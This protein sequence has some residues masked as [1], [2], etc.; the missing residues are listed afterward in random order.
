MWQ[1]WTP[2]S[3]AYTSSTH[4]PLC[5]HLS[6]TPVCHCRCEYEISAQ[7][8]SYCEKLSQRPAN[9]FGL[10]RKAFTIALTPP[11]FCQFKPCSCVFST[12][13]QSV[14]WQEILCC[15]LV[16]CRKPGR[17]ACLENGQHGN[18]SYTMWCNAADQIWIMGQWTMRSWQGWGHKSLRWRGRQDGV[19]Y[20]WSKLQGLKKLACSRPDS[21]EGPGQI[22]SLAETRNEKLWFN[23]FG[24]VGFNYYQDV[25][26]IADCTYLHLSA[27]D[28]PY[29]ASA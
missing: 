9:Y 21:D 19:S 14:C 16:D 6:D 7:G 2:T 4:P 17:L 12:L 3:H 23:V 11:P 28:I 15:P 1:T 20:Q 29:S 13:S 25:K 8:A 27:F 24:S 5:T 18:E 22:T 10:T 26:N